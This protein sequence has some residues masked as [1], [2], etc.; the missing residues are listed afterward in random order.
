MSRRT[1]FLFNIVKHRA[2]FLMLLL[3][4]LVL[5][6]NN[7]IPMFGVIV[8]FKNYNFV[9]GILHSPWEGIGNFKYL[10]QTEDAW[11]AT[12]N[13]VLYNAL[14]IVL[15]TACAIF[16]AIALNEL[17]SKKL[18]KFFQSSLLFPYFLSF[19]VVSYLAYAFL[20]GYGYINKAILE[21]LGYSEISWYTES[22]YWTVILPLV[23]L[24]K[25]IGYSMVVYLA[26][27]VGI[28]QEYYEAAVIDGASKWQQIRKITIPLMSPVIIVLVIL[29]I[30]RIFNADFGLF[31]QVPLN[32]GALYDTTN[33]IDTFVYRSLLVSGNVGMSAAAGL[34]QSAVGIVLVLLTNFVVRKVSKENAL[35]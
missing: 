8:A 19:V 11:V 16:L 18:T 26:A 27:I 30:G 7:Y 14:F 1:G 24:W 28:D 4:L 15:N 10:F 13:T 6:F 35:F 22:K 5:I 31:F 12:R 20:G 32:T 23:N 33:V 34:Y 9:D 17:R 29:Q 3:P 2:L 25:N 21:P